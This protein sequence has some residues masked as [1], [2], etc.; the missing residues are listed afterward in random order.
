MNLI[1]ATREQKPIKEEVQYK[2]QGRE[3][4][5]E[6]I[7]LVAGS[8]GENGLRVNVVE[9]HESDDAQGVDSRVA[10][11]LKELHEERL[12]E[13]KMTVRLTPMR[14][15]SASLLIAY[16]YYM[17]STFSVLDHSYS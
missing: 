16:S 12:E 13:S 8:G 15:A 10:E 2:L 5:D 1:S 14:S 6:M 3:P 7:P 9:V 17:F 11:Y 4:I